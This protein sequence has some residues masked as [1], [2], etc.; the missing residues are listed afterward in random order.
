ME[1]GFSLNNTVHF[2]RADGT[3][4]FLDC[5]TNRYACLKPEQASQFQEILDAGGSAGS[6]SSRT[7]SFAGYLVRSG[8]LVERPGAACSLQ[9]TPGP[10]TRA[11]LLDERQTSDRGALIAIP[12]MARSVLSAWRLTRQ[13]DMTLA[14]EA[15]R[16]WRSRTH[17]HSSAYGRDARQITL[18]FHDLTPFFFT[19]HDACLF[20]S[21]AL[22]RFLT[23]HGCS[24]DWVFGVCYCP[25]LAHCWVERDGEILNDYL[26]NVSAYRPILRI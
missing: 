14:M 6:L 1:Q 5:R 16:N 19:A 7:R 15:V 10:R 9:E 25:F 11:S 22:M 3:F 24:A 23:L 13:S 18:A 12:A 8:I 26:E 20:R 21:L 2:C 4:I 17:R